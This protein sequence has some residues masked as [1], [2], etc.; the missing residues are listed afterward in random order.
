[1]HYYVIFACILGTWQTVPSFLHQVSSRYK[2]EININTKSQTVKLNIIGTNRRPNSNK[3]RGF[4]TRVLINAGVFIRS[5]T[6]YNQ[7]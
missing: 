7:S 6:V 1:M 5:F 3:R 4:E 2:A